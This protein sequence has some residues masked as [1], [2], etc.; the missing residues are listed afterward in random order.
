MSQSLTVAEVKRIPDQLRHATIKNECRSCDCL[1][2]LITQLE[3]DTGEDVSCMTDPFKAAR[4][5]L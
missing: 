5:Q 3:L 1:Q 4:A 2:G